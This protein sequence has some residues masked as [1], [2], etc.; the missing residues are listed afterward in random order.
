MG[1]HLKQSPCY[2]RFMEQKTSFAAAKAFIFNAENKFLVIKQHIKDL[3]YYDLPGGKIQDE[4]TPE[5]C[6]H[7]EL[8]EEI[9]V[10][11]FSVDKFIGFWRFTRVK[12][13]IQVFCLTYKCTLPSEVKI[14]GKDNPSQAEQKENIDF[15]WLT[16]E[17]FA[18]DKYHENRNNRSLQDLVRFL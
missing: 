14:S 4:E 13:G 5:D 18:E 15:L 3:D 2:T 11:Q 9:G 10:S 8:A 16:K 1:F 12:D 17:E 7:R 6:L